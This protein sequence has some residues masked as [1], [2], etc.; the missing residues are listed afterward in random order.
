MKCSFL[1]FLKFIQLLT[2]AT[3]LLLFGCTTTP[4]QS[5]HNILTKSD[6]IKYLLQKS[7]SLPDSM[8]H[9]AFIFTENAY[10]LAMEKSA[11]KPIMLDIYYKLGKQAGE[12]GYYDL[13]Y[14]YL[15]EAQKIVGKSYSKIAGDIYEML[16]KVALKKNKNNLSLEYHNKALEI[17][18]KIDDREGQASSYFKI[19][20]IYHY[21]QT[22]KEASKCYEK[23]L[24]IYRELNNK[25]EEAQRYKELEALNTLED[26]FTISYTDFMLN[27]N[28]EIVLEDISSIEMCNE[29]LLLYNFQILQQRKHYQTRLHRIIII[30]LSIVAFFAAIGLFTSYR[31][32]KQNKK[33]REETAK[34]MRAAEL[35]QQA[36]LPPKEYLDAILPEHFIYFNPLE[37][38]SGDFY[39]IKKINDYIVVAVADC[40]GHGIPGAILSMLGISSLYKITN[41]METPQADKILN[42]LRDEI[43]RLLNPKGRRENQLHGM[44]IALAVINKQSCEIDFA[45]AYNPLFL[46][47][48]G[49]LTEIKGDRMPVGWYEF[50]K[51][52]TSKRFKYENDDVIY[53]FSDGYADQFGNDNQNKQKK[54]PLFSKNRTKKFKTKKFRNLLLEIS[55]KPLDEQFRILDEK[56]LQWKGTSQQT[57]DILIVGIRFNEN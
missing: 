25:I 21:E 53:M 49:K 29:Q 17:R 56:H 19:G 46:I 55:K 13:A 54:R 23:S 37:I 52:F 43:S 36:T 18:I 9:E 6:S 50:N 11:E 38:V 57:D 33:A 2:V 41:K 32:Y 34:S 51:P 26:N 30:A 3:T 15:L 28:L 39:W 12:L 40:T 27:N 24:L 4:N 35:I 42:D 8:V 47:R 5:E 31:A 22:H 20:N 7:A 1:K 48:K 16:G 10:R 44:N 14:S 45:G